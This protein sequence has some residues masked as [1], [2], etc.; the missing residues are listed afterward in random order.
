M[1]EAAHV[2]AA[3][4]Q[5]HSRFIRAMRVVL[6]A[7]IVALAALLAM[8]MTTHEVRV[9]SSAPRETASRFHMVN[10]HFFGRDSQGRA[11]EIRAA[12]AARSDTDMQVVL[13]DHVVMALDM[14]GAQPRRLSADHG[15][16][17]EDTRILRLTSNV[18]VDDGRASSVVTNQAIVDTRAG[19]VSGAQH[20]DSQTTVGS[21]QAGQ[22]T[23]LEKG[24]RVILRGGVHARINSH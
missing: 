24:N 22:Y 13:L 1:A 23:V 17:R 6:P 7:A 19:T 5:A 8:F 11:F 20:V 14:N 18:H 4:L 21:M 15:V 12:E 3:G 9:R 10:P 2:T 16:Y